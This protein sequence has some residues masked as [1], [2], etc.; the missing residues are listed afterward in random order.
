MALRVR[1]FAKMVDHTLLKPD[2]S[3]GDIRRLC[4]EASH[5]HFA[6][7][8]VPP[9]YVRLA[10]E[11]LRGVDVKVCTV[12]SFP[13]GNDV[14][15]VK[16]AAVREAVA[17]GASELDVVMNISRFLSGDFSYVADELTSLI[18]EVSALAIS[19][20]LGDIIVKV[21][22]ETAYLTNEMKRLAVQMVADSGADFIKTS[23]G[24]GPAG[25]TAEDVALLRE[26]APDA[27]AI[28][29][30]GGIGTLED[31]LAML[32]AG[33]S[34]IGASRS[35]AIMQEAENGGLQE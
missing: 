6:S 14:T 26:E 7:V 17:A 4:E 34:R 1:E 11:E 18:Q 8:C 13:F 32:D 20:G 25:A 15:G 22:V 5:Y 9:C 30:S 16:V 35:V 29:A 2:A 28:K 23:T 31:A 27:L 33:A 21:I 10:A 12:V 3:E 19:N 24:F